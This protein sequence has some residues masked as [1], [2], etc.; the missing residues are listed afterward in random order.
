MTQLAGPGLQFHCSIHPPESPREIFEPLRV[1]NEVGFDRV[2]IPDQTFHCDPFVVLAEAARVSDIPV[3]L[4][5]TNPFSRHPVQIAR[6]IATLR[7]LCPRPDW[8]FAIGASNPRTV[9]R[10]L[11]IPM[12][13]PARNIGESVRVIRALL[14]GERVTSTDPRLSFAADGVRLEIDPA[15]DVSVLIGTRGPQTLRQAGRFADGVIVESMFAPETIA[16]AK[17]HISA[18]RPTAPDRDHQ[19]YIAWQITEVVEPGTSLPAHAER[20]ARM[21]MRTTHPQVLQM[22]GF[23]EPLIESVKSDDAD[24]SV[25]EWALRRFAAFGTAPEVRSLVDGARRS[26]ADAWSCTFTGSASVTSEDMRK[27]AAD[28]IRP[29]REQWSAADH[30]ESNEGTATSQ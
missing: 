8:A 24:R 4:S 19:P 17:R 11:R 28:I 25:P 6:S 1:A 23:T 26:G 5:V 30:D 9:L 3:G 15:D 7:Q 10:P 27:F 21:L 13:N 12:V 20:S 22:M 18:G 29:L 2:W 16:W 14:R